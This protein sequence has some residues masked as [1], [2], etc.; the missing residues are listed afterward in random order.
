[1]AKLKFTQNDKGEDTKVSTGM[2]SKDGEYVDMS[3]S[4]DLS[5]QV[6][7]QENLSNLFVKFGPVA[8]QNHQ[9]GQKLWEKKKNT[10]KRRLQKMFLELKFSK[11]KL[12]LKNP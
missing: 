6:R 10:I 8:L 4:C 11:L 1:M 12:I 5:G 7:D 3:S 9:N 2:Y